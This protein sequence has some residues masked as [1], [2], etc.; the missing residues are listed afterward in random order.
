MEQDGEC[1]SSHS[2]L[3]TLRIDPSHNLHLLL[4]CTVASLFATSDAF[5]KFETESSCAQGSTKA[6][7]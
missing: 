2:T 3:P 6:Q 5:S 1:G 4:L 7:L